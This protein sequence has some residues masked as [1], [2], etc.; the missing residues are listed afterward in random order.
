LFPG[1]DGILLGTRIPL[2]I[3]LEITLTGDY[4]DAERAYELG[5]VNRVVPPDQVLDAALDL[6]TRIAANGPLA[7]K[8]T[9]ELTRLAVTSVEQ[10][11]ARQQEWYP[12]IFQ[13]EDAKEGATAFVEKREPVWRGR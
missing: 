1:G 11:H 8:A 10:A 6:A 12:I 9:K 7:I 13:S 4:I 2:P 5:I 3:A